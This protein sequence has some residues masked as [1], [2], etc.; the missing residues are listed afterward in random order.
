MPGLAQ[1][2]ILIRR[3]RRILAACCAGLAALL[4]VSVIRSPQAPAGAVADGEPTLQPGQ[5]GVPIALASAAHAGALHAGDV[6]DLIAVP[7]AEDSSARVVAHAATVLSIATGG[8]G[9]ADGSVVVIAVPRSDA[10]AIANA[11][12]AST[13][14]AWVTSAIPATASPAG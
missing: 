12:S 13:F 9:A 3:H 7:R 4:A 14:T 11:L 2:R 1:L 8:F 6:I 10:L 5:V